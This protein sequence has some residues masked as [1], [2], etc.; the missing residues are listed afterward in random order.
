MSLLPETLTLASALCATKTIIRYLPLAGTTEALLQLDFCV[1][2]RAVFS[3]WKYPWVFQREIAHCI[4][5]ESNRKNG[6]TWPRFYEFCNIADIFGSKRQTV[7]QTSSVRAWNRLK[8]VPKSHEMKAAYI[9][10]QGMEG[11]AHKTCSLTPQGE[12]RDTQP[13]HLT[14]VIYKV[15]M[16]KHF[17]VRDSSGASGGIRVKVAVTWVGDLVVFF[18]LPAPR[19]S[20]LQT[21]QIL[22]RL[23]W[24]APSCNKHGS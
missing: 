20:V 16:H 14:Q 9:Y 4:R 10:L 17:Q 21:A 11:K 5:P 8:N 22:Q 24:L 7:S 18:K 13:F 3:L 23:L 2:S 15:L 12:E 1:H 6:A 19:S